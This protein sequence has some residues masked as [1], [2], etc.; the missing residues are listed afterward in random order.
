MTPAQWGTLLILNLA[1]AASPGPDILLITRTAIRSRRHAV[2]TV[3]GIQVGVLFWC[4]LTV[5]GF[6]ALLTAFPAI[7][8]FLQLV[9]GA[10]LVWMGYGMLSG[11]LSE[12]TNPPA[13][14]Q[15][16]QAR[17][18]RL[19]HAFLHGLTTNLSNPKI[20]LFLSALIAPLLPPSPS[21]W[22]AAA[23]V[24][25]LS[26]SSVILQLGMALLVSTPAMR[27]KLLRAGPWIDIVS[28]IFFMVAGLVLVWN[29]V[30]DLQG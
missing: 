30:E 27:Q 20:V 28:G 4:T 9:G 2:A 12:R 10:W 25:M 15:E 11:G 26:V 18:G 7:L 17:L 19:R 29:G 5:L 1:G 6:A 16:A 21:L 8:G 14:L 13:D 3:L 22:L 23:V 24:A